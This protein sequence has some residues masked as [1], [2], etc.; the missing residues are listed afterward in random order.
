MVKYFS[1]FDQV[2]HDDDLPATIN[3]AKGHRLLGNNELQVKYERWLCAFPNK[4]F[5]EKR[6]MLEEFCGLFLSLIPTCS[7][8]INQDALISLIIRSGVWTLDVVYFVNILLASGSCS[9]VIFD[10]EWLKY[11]PPKAE[12]TDWICDALTESTNYAELSGV[13]FKVADVPVR[14]V[15]RNLLQ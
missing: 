2:W 5:M 13:E 9:R 12:C 15:T 11:D 7:M 8:F 6:A 3:M 1:P 10:I 4:L 14:P